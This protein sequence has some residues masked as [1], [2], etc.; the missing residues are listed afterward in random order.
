[1]NVLQGI[2]RGRP[3][4]RLGT[5]GSGNGLVRGRPRGRLGREASATGCLRGRPRRF[6]S[7]HRC[8]SDLVPEHF[9]ETPEVVGQAT[10][11]SFRLSQE[12]LSFSRCSCAEC[13]MET[14]KVVGAP[15]HI[16]TCLGSLEPLSSMAALARSRRQPFSDRSIQP[17]E[18]RGVEHLPA[19]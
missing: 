3:R 18:V 5:L 2:F 8:R 7:R 4:G 17:F 15:N 12:L 11:Q 14:A 9:R 19:C 16:P 10:G 6:G 1:M 13:L